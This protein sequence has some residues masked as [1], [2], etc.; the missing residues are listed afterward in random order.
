MTNV[1]MDS[2]HIYNPV[3]YRR[4]FAEI[5][6][7]SSIMYVS[8]DFVILY[9]HSPLYVHYAFSLP[10]ITSVRILFFKEDVTDIF[11][12]LPSI[13]EPQTT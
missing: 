3:K 7:G 11:C 1:T 2:P 6:K 9:P 5:V 10:T 4:F 13:K 8:L 12:E